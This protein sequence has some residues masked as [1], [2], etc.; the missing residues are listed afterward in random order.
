MKN[1]PF[2]FGR[3][4]SGKDF[5]DR[6]NEIQ[7][8]KQNFLAGTNTI[9]ISPR[10]WGKSSLIKKAGYELEQSNKNIRVVHI[11][12]FNIRTEEDFYKE[13]SENIF[14][15]VSDKLDELI[16]NSK[17]F[18]KQW[19]PKITFSPDAQQEIS[20][21]LNW[22]DVKR[23]PDEIL[24]LP[25]E[26]AKDKGYRIVIC[27][28]E[29]QN[30]G[31]FDDPLAFQKKL[32]AHWQKHQQATYCLYG[33]KR[34]M[35]MEVFASPSMPFY[36]FGDLMFLNKI[37]VE[38]WKVFIQKRFRSTG[39][40]ITKKQAGR[41]AFIAK[42]HPHYVQ[43]LSQLCWF[44][45]KKVFEDN[46]I[47]EAVESLVLQLNLLF[48]SITESLSTTQVNFLKALIDGVEQY[49]SKDTINKYNLGT[50]SNVIRIKKALTN[51][52]IIDEQPPGK[53]DILD[54]IYEIWLRDYYFISG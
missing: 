4:T 48:Q 3:I 30:L 20:F 19:M 24:N 18:L 21:G 37:S 53:L 2:I 8:L 16:A 36:K 47:D 40:K 23:Q 35:L 15:A 25:E 22:S 42:N 46:I 13:F 6:E 50:S 38:Y 29:F 27:I 17:K 31:F 33:S 49:S 1:T 7:H 45:T 52:E 10:R 5:T 28:D 41:I 54:P 44:R 14:K 32:R 26:I 9:L 12:M 51:K 43:Q 39:K 11:D 34:H